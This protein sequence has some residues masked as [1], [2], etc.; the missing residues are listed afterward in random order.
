M[1]FGCGLAK[2][3]SQMQGWITQAQLLESINVC[4]VLRTPT[5][6]HVIQSDISCHAYKHGMRIRSTLC[7]RVCLI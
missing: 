4:N 5:I 3:K 7:V 2:T 1:K 6:R